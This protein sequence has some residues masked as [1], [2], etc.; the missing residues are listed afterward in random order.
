MLTSTAHAEMSRSVQRSHAST[1]VRP[2]CFTTGPKAGSGHATAKGQVTMPWP[3]H[4]AMKRIAAK[5]EPGPAERRYRG[6]FLRSHIDNSSRASA[7]RCPP[8]GPK[9]RGKAD[10]QAILKCDEVDREFKSRRYRS[11]P[12]QLKSS[13]SRSR[14]RR[15][16]NHN[17]DRQPPLL[18][19][20]A[21]ARRGRSPPSRTGGD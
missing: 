16:R 18:S 9:D 21:E 15:S 6:R 5:C 10:D 11:S 8:P 14:S 1:E 13:P 2:N 3:S 4:P 17:R 20:L 7:G 12:I 19:Q